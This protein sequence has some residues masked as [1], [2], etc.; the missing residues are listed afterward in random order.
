MPENKNPRTIW[1]RSGDAVFH[2]RANVLPS[3]TKADIKKHQGRSSG[4]RFILLAAPSHPCGQWLYAAFIPG[5]SGGSATALHRTSLSRLSRATLN[6]AILQ[7]SKEAV[8]D[9]GGRRMRQAD[10]STTTRP[11]KWW[12]APYGAIDF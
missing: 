10:I 8:K 9:E 12:A 4:S 2:P 3:S 6:G 11:F 7:Q 5:Y 1:N